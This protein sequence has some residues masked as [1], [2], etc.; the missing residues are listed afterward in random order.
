MQ[1]AAYRTDDGRLVRR[2]AICPHLGC[3]VEWNPADATFDCV[4]HGSIFDRTGRCV[5]GP[6]NADLPDV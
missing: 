1:V 6:A 5:N 3:C 2:S 4:C